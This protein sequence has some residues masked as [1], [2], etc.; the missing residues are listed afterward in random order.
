[1]SDN[2]EYFIA[3]GRSLEAV[4]AFV[5]ERH[6]YLDAINQLIAEYGASNLLG[7]NRGVSAFLFERGAQIPAGLRKDRR[8]LGAAG[9]VPHKRTPEGKKIAERMAEVNKLAPGGL[10]GRL[11]NSEYSLGIMTDNDAR[12]GMVISGV[13]AEQL[14]GRWVLTVPVPLGKTR[15]P[16]PFDAEPM[17]RSVYWRLKEAKDAQNENE[18][19]GSPA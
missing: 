12:G 16:V 4:E 19:A 14:D 5:G 10:V 18:H 3:K 7:S 1:M 8:G 2:L 6:A 9:Y 13:G 17:A 11:F 15:A